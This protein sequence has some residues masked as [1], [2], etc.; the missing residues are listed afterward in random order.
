ML[1]PRRNLGH[2]GKPMQL[3]KGSRVLDLGT[4]AR[5][6][7]TLLPVAASSRSIKSGDSIVA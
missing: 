7:H 5:A 1:E 3:P 6:A 4:T 2:R